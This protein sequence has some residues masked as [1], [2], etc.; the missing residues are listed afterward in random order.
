MFEIA[1]LL[2]SS[3]ITSFFI[4]RFLFFSMSLSSWSTKTFLP[5][6][7]NWGVYCWSCSKFDWREL[8]FSMNDLY[9]RIKSS[10]SYSFF[11]TDLSRLTFFYCNPLT[12][13][14]TLFN[15]LSISFIFY[16]LYSLFTSF[17][18]WNCINSSIYCRS[19]IFCS[20]SWSSFSFSWIRTK[21]RSWRI[22]FWFITSS[23][24]FFNT[25]SLFSSLSAFS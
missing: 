23:I 12:F 5:E 15:F 2:F 14:L 19:S 11:W 13:L 9:S 17:P 24:L 6:F 22:R 8:Y 4:S 18:P 7:S 3:S 10:S 16:E 1:S 21:N 25:F 20:F